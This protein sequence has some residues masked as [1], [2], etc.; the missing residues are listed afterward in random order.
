MITSDRLL[1]R[2]HTP[3][4]LEAILA[5][6]TDAAVNQF[7]RGMPTTR[8]EAWRR[9]LQHTGHWSL[10]GYGM[11]AVVERATGTVMGELGL[12]N[13]HRGLGA[14]FDGSPEAGWLLKG[15]FHGKGYASEAMSAVFRWFDET[16]SELRTVCIIDPD[17]ASSIQLATRLGFN[18][19]GA[20]EYRGTTVTMFERQRPPLGREASHLSN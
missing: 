12:G 2:P 16:R 6:T 1:L 17:N 18:P 19:F 9:L 15:T 10:F 13:F 3:E 5:V 11:L 8:E 20:S 14:S 4:D 7:I